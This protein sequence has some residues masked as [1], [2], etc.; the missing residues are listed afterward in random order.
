M[1][2]RASCSHDDGDGGGGGDPACRQTLTE[3]CCYRSRH[4]DVSAYQSALGR[5][6]HRG[7][8]DSAFR[9]ERVW[10][11]RQV[12]NVSGSVVRSSTCLALSSGHRRVWL[13]RQVIDVSGSVVRSST[14]LA[15]SSGHRRVWFCRQV[16]RILAL[17][18]SDCRQFGLAGCAPM[19]LDS[20]GPHH[21][22]AVAG[23][24]SNNCSRL[25]TAA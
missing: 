4:C 9:A 12:I 15:L 13:C 10:L 22:F 21:C 6:F 23:H 7:A 19:R 8:S 14:Y 17:H 20:P 5:S 16:I 1:N 24:R 25:I 3:R 18:S 2:R 11:C